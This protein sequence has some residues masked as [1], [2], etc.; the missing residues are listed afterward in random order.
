MTHRAGI[1]LPLGA[2]QSQLLPGLRNISHTLIKID[3]ALLLT[4]R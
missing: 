3:L 1:A 4:M 2:R